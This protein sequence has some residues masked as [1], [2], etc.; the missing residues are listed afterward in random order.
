CDVIHGSVSGSSCTGPVV[1]VASNGTAVAS[2]GPKDA[3][4]IDVNSKVG[5]AA[6]ATTVS[7]TDNATT[8]YG[9]NVFVVGSVPGLG[10][11]N[12]ADAITLSSA[13]YPNGSGSVP[14][15]ANTAVQYKYI[16]KDASGTVI[17]EGGSNRSFT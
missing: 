4:A 2:V 16:K 3:V 10:N 13:G 15:P 6:S 11:W 9:Q 1:V 14:L 5:A 8:V 12:T 7:F 17:W